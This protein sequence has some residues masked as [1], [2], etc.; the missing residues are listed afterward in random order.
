MNLTYM[1]MDDAVKCQLA[2]TSK[3]LVHRSTQLL[4]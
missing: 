4:L 2:T 1:C 3:Q